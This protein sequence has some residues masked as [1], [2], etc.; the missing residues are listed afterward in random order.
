MTIFSASSAGVGG[1]NDEIVNGT[2]LATCRAACR[3][4]WHSRNTLPLE[5]LVEPYSG[6]SEEGYDDG[7][8]AFHS[9]TSDR[10]TAAKKPRSNAA[11]R[12]VVIACAVILLGLASAA[13]VYVASTRLQ[14]ARSAA[15]G[16]PTLGTAIIDSK[17]QGLVTIEGVVRGQTPLSLRLP[18]GIHNITIAAGQVSRSVALEIE[19]GTTTRQYI[20]FAAAPAVAATTGRLDVTSQPPGASVTVDGNRRGLTPI[21][22][23]EM[24][25]G[26]H[27]VTISSGDSTI[28]RAVTIRPGAISSVDASI[29]SPESAAGMAGAR[30]SGRIDAG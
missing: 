25:V 5:R 28:H 1:R 6:G 10:A 30:V 11:R 21:S 29:A 4:F 16:E 17:P 27:Q 26:P 14:A 22:I 13:V 3:T 12:G 19:A 20:E 2:R 23:A 7:L 18:A 15:T 8:L 9:E 24:A